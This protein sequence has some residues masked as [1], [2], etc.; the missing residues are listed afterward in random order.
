MHYIARK[1]LQ[2]RRRLRWALGWGWDLTDFADRYAG[3]ASD[4]WSYANDSTHLS[5]LQR[6]LNVLSPLEGK[7]VLELGCAE[8]FI[9]QAI[10]QH[11]QQVTACELSPLAAERTRTLCD[12]LPV[13]VIAGDIRRCLPE[14]RFDLILA[15]DVFYYLTRDELVQVTRALAK[16][17]NA[18][19]RLVMANEWNTSYTQLTPPQQIIETIADTREWEF[20]QKDV[21]E[22]ATNSHTIATFR[23]RTN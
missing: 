23:L 12:G 14:E 2:I 4:S 3:R 13:K 19:C 15:S 17:A 1:W 9:T 8:G 16:R 22:N 6:I 11:A 21:D 10:A 20:F 7:K 18:D 5:R